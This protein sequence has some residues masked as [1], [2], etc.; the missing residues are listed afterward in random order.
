MVENFFHVLVTVFVLVFS[1]HILVCFFI[2]IG[3][4]D[5]NYDV[6]INWIERLGFN[7]EDDYVDEQ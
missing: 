6:N 3:H 5:A 1:I 7:L 4:T 2:A